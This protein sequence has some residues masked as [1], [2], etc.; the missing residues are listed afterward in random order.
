MVPTTEYAVCTY[1]YLF[2]H[3]YIRIYGTVSGSLQSS[4]C[5]MSIMECVVYALATVERS[6][7]QQVIVYC[8]LPCL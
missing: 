5:T 8:L 3:S 4:L 7:L 2:I 1:I 6:L